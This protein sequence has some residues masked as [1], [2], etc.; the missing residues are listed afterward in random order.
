MAITD[1]QKVD[2]L[3][4]KIGYGRAKTDTG[5]LKAA[6][7]ESISSPLL[8]RGDKVWSQANLVPGVMPGS[9]SGIVTV[10]PTSSPVE[11]AADTTSSL[12]RTWKTNIT[13]WIPPEIGSTYLVKV[14]LHTPG[15]AASAASSGTQ[16][17]GA[18]SGND[19]EWFFDYQSGTLNFIG[20]NLPSGISGKS[21][22]VSGAVYAGI[23]GV[24]VPGSQAA[25]TDLFV[26]GIST[27]TGLLDANGGAEIKNIRIGVSTNNEIDT[28]VGNLIL[29]S[30]TGF[31]SIDDALNVSGI[32]TFVG[33]GT[34]LSDLY[35]GG[36]FGVQGYSEFV[37]VVTFKGG[38]INL[39]DDTGD[40]INVGG[41][42]TSGLYPNASNTYDLGDGARQWRHTSFAGIGTFD[43]GIDASNIRI[44]ADD[45]NKITTSS[46]NLVLDPAGS[47]IIQD[48]TIIQNDLTVNGNVT[49]GGT[50]VT[51]LGQDVYIENKDIILGYTT[52]VT[53]TDTS[54][55]H[56]GVAIASTEG[57]PLVSFTASGINTLPDT[58]K[59]MMWFKSGT[60]GFS[61]DAFAF[62]YGVAIGT[63]QMASGVRLAVG[64]GVTVS[65][66]SVSATTFY[67]SLVGNVSSADQVKT[68][69]AADANANYHVTFV[70]ANNGSATNESIYTD[71][72][73]YYNPGTN[74]LTTQHA[75][76]TGNTL[77]SGI[78]TFTGAI[79]ANGG[80]DI[81]GGETTLSSATVSDLTAGRVVL[82]G[83]SGALEDSSNLTFG[84]GGLIIGAGGINVTGVSTFSTDVVV[85]GDIRING[86][87]IKASDGNT[88]I[89]LTSNTLTTFAGDV[90]I[91]GNDIQASDG[92]VAVSISTITGNVK[93]AGDLIAGS[94]YLASANGT[95]AM[96]MYDT[97]GDVSFQG[98]VVAN[99]FRSSTNASNTLSFVDLDATF[100]RNLII[101][102]I[103]TVG[104][105]V[106]ITQFSSAV[107]SGTS[108]SSV[109]TSSAIID[110]VD[111]EIGAINLTLGLNADSGGPSTLNTSQ[112]LVINGTANEV[113]TSVSAQTIT[114][115][116]PNAVVVGTSLSAPTLRSGTI[117][118]SSTGATAITI[119][120]N[121]VTVADDLTVQGNLYVNGNTTQVNTASLT[122]EDRTIDLGIVNGAAPS[123]GTTW[124]LGVLFNYYSGSAKKSAVIWEHG[125][126]RFK[127][128]SILDSDTEG[129]TTTTPQLT[130]NT[131]APIEI[132]SLWVTD[133]A[134]TSQVISCTGSTRNLENITIDAGT[135]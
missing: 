52:S 61:T 110:Y 98:K 81:S 102:G 74:K 109:P 2:Y 30:A 97:S 106:G 1:T 54:A 130:V 10:Y 25:F 19:D 75:E 129:T 31:T 73:I 131:Y 88:N 123:T 63:T 95:R 11:C 35:V 132:G 122:V 60:L 86:N 33:V 23:L 85:D 50:T 89:T 22:Y 66:T 69:T 7:N 56:A 113:E 91:G 94:G 59:Q 41:E 44:G 125:D 4:K 121:D 37:G 76:F 16:I 77:V 78:S 45:A 71:D 92:T 126:S 105:G 21:V 27:L 104:T 57:T 107:G 47:V 15:N 8:L 13:D 118:S 119:T 64:S 46:G 55:N 120:D 28:S 70:D 40:N 101:S 67:G 38:L 83:T 3:W 18:G 72:G 115:G 53:P 90:K 93:S 112:T 133:C 65:D 42:F 24:A 48:N 26:S 96:Y 108:T 32:S 5:T 114:V 135:F 111:A 12:N 43:G 124:D 49:I 58:Y 20:A 100:A 117:Q 103:T 99:S 51:L 68:V 87:D 128:A 29:D 82:A 36:N 80:A 134:G 116:L 84:S 9:T 14:Y 62:N 79:D 34:F 17:Y 39:G 6:T 127:F